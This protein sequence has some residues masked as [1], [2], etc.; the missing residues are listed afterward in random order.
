M[1]KSDDTMLG[2]TSCL[3][4]QRFYDHFKENY[5]FERLI[6]QLRMGEIFYFKLLYLS[7]YVIVKQLNFNS[8]KF[9]VRNI[10]LIYILLHG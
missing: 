10:T 7:N 6:W 9:V 3:L 5:H 4:K 8:I 2:I 1:Y